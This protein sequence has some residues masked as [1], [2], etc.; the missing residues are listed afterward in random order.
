MQTKEASHE[1]GQEVAQLLV[2]PPRKRSEQGERESESTQNVSPGRG[3]QFFNLALRTHITEAEIIDFTGGEIE[4]V[5]DANAVIKMCSK[6]LPVVRNLS[7]WKERKWKEEATVGQV[8]A[9]ISDTVKA[10]NSKWKTHVPVCAL[11]YGD[12]RGDYRRTGWKPKEKKNSDIWVVW[13]Y[14]TSQLATMPSV[15][16]LPELKKKSPALY[17]I[18]CAIIGRLHKDLGIHL[19]SYMTD[20]AEIRAEN[21]AD[22]WPNDDP[23]PE[24]LAEAEDAQA[25][26]KQYWEDA[27]PTLKYVD[28]M[29]KTSITKLNRMVRTYRWD[30]PFKKKIKAW[31]ESTIVM[32]RNKKAIREFSVDNLTWMHGDDFA[33]QPHHYMWFR[34]FGQN[35]GNYV[36]NEID[37]MM[38]NCY[39][40]GGFYP[41]RRLFKYTTDAEFQKVKNDRYPFE[42]EKLMMDALDVFSRNFMKRFNK[43]R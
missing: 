4:S 38:E 32:L 37:Q 11:V 13:A 14:E 21:M 36:E 15:S 43:Q 34:W 19:W 6:L 20:N 31:V 23:D 3:D 26:I 25:D 24:F 30:T 17:N 27:G 8:L 16:F 35:S 33:L 29:G 7:Q 12:P 40:E 5:G 9:H 42:L 28:R 18:L 41:F 22:D 39:N 10:W 1:S 2:K